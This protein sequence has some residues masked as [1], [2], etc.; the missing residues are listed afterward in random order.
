MEVSVQT[1]TFFLVRGC[2]MTI[3]GS[4]AVAAKVRERLTAGIATKVCCQLR[5]HLIPPLPPQR[6]LLL[7]L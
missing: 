4:K 5:L 2:S 1:M 3:D 7:L 6:L